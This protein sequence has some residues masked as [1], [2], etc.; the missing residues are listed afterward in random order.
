VIRVVRKDEIRTHHH[1]F[2]LTIQNRKLIKRN[3]LIRYPAR[4]MS[5]T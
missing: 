2:P 5:L 4:G 3:V 1:F